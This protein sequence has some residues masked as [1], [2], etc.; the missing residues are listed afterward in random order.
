MNGIFALISQI[1]K[2]PATGRQGL[3]RGRLLEVL[4]CEEN[5]ILTGIRLL[6]LCFSLVVC[7]CKSL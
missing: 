4:L 3:R 6:L 5:P 2:R 7:Q 1:A